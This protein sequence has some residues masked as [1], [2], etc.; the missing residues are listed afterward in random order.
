MYT[1][2][3]VEW[4]GRTLTLAFP[5]YQ[6]GP[7]VTSLG[8]DSLSGTRPHCPLSHP[9]SQG[10]PVMLLR[11]SLP[12][13]LQ[14]VLNAQL[15]VHAPLRRYSLCCCILITF[16]CFLLGDQMVGN[17]LPAFQGSRW[18]F[19]TLVLTGCWGS[20]HYLQTP[21]AHSLTKLNCAVIFWAIATPLLKG[22]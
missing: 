5:A 10:T 8:C 17:L 1:L 22:E 20:I 3:C 6:T 7:E 19:P 9:K 18:Y 16:S 11:L 15:S 13:C 4:L 12:T 14:G 2:N 21:L